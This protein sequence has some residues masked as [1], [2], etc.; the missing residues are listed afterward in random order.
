VV[1][2]AWTARVVTPKNTAMSSAQERRSLSFMVFSVALAYLGDS[3]RGDAY[4]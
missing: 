3:V 1:D 4:R 2:C